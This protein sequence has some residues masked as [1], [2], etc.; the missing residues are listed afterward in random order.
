VEA[1]KKEEKRK[2]ER[3]ETPLLMLFDNRTIKGRKVQRAPKHGSDPCPQP[4]LAVFFLH[5]ITL[6]LVSPSLCKES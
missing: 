5:S 2:G 3:N 4:K 6:N 1:K